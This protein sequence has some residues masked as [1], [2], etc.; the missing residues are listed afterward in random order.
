MATPRGINRYDHHRENLM[1]RLSG[2]VAP[3]IYGLMRIIVGLLFACQGAQKLFGFFGGV[4]EEP[5]ATVQLISLM[6]LAGVIELVGGLLIAIGLLTRLAAFI[7]SGQMA[8][9]Y[10]MAHAPRGTWPIENGG[11]LSVVYCFLFLYIAA[12]GTGKLGL[13]S[14]RDASNSTPMERAEPSS[15]RIP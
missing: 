1:G 14:S 10:F 2:T 8:A 4:G 6:G 13:S 7:A 12:R 11:E 15:T 5:G 9:A 3:Y